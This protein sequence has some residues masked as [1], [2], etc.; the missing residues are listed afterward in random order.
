L[1]DAAREARFLNVPFGN[2]VDPFGEPVKKAF[3][4]YPEAQ[5]QGKA[6]EFVSAYLSAAFALGTDITSTEGLAEVARAAGLD[7]SA[8]VDGDNSN[9]QQ[10]LEGNLQQMLDAGLW[11]VPSFRLSGGNTAEPFSC[12]GQDRLWVLESEIYRRCQTEQ[13]GLGDS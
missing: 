12:W 4:L 8:L 5:R 3:A 11:G 1:Q 6:M 2:F 7:Y 13:S 9:W 10:I